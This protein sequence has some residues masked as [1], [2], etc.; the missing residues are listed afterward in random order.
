MLK[1]GFFS[2]SLV[3]CLKSARP[4]TSRKAGYSLVGDHCIDLMITVIATKNS[5]N[6]ANQFRGIQFA[7]ERKFGRRE[8]AVRNVA[9]TE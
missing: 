9:G 2:K 7:S 3:L 6:V 8:T 5:Q 4:T 1:S